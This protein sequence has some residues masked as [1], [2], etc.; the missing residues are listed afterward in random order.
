ME[1]V[2]LVKART[3]LEEKKALYER[4]AG[5]HAGNGT[6]AGEEKGGDDA[7]AASDLAEGHNR[8][9]KFVV[10][11]ETLAEV[12]AA[13]KRLDQGTYGKCLRC[14]ADLDPERLALFPEAQSCVNN[15]LVNN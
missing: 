14:G 5:E 12:L 11:K 3:A 8:T 7:D 10:F 15:C 9:A 4:L 13:L 1:V 2:D 6:K